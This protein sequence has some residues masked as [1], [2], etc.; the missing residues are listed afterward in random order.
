MRKF[1]IT[2]LLALL[3]C[4][5][6]SAQNTI[7]VSACNSGRGTGSFSNPYSKIFYALDSC[8]ANDTVYINPGIYNE[9]SLF[10]KVNGVQ[11]IGKSFDNF[12]TTANTSAIIRYSNNSVLKFINI[13]EKSNILLKNIIVDMDS[14][15]SECIYIDGDNNKVTNCYIKRFNKDAI[16]I[17]G[18]CYN[19]ISN[20]IIGIVEDTTYKRNSVTVE[21]SFIDGVYLTADNNLIEGNIIFHNRSHFGINMILVTNRGG[22]YDSTQYCFG[23]IIRRNRIDS[24]WS[25][26]YM[27]H[28]KNFD[29]NNNIISNSAGP[30]N[31][32][33]GH[34]INID[35]YPDRWNYYDA[36]GVIQNNDIYNNTNIGL[37][38]KYATGLQVFNNIFLDN[39]HPDAPGNGDECLRINYS[40]NDTI[41]NNLYYGRVLHWQL[42]NTY[43]SDSSSWKIIETNAIFSDPRLLDPPNKD[44]RLSSSSPAIDRGLDLTPYS[45]YHYDYVGTP[46]PQGLHWDVG[47]Y[48][49]TM[50]NPFMI[51][52]VAVSGI[53]TVELTFNRDINADLVNRYSFY[54]DNNIVKDVKFLA[55]D[56][57]EI[58]ANEFEGNKKYILII[59]E[60]VDKLGNIISPQYRAFLL[61]TEHLGKTSTNANKINSF[62][63]SQNYP[64]P[65][66]PSTSIKCNIAEDGKYQLK[67]YNVLGEEVT[68]LNN[69]VLNRGEHSFTFNAAN[70]PSGVYIYRLTGNNVNISRKMI[71]LK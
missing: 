14:S 32:I 4:F 9:D 61:K 33:E 2:L 21:G 49:Y 58:T 3:E 5:N 68:V 24:C 69:G 47:C 28:Q 64:N 62:S 51:T 71:L 34:G 8:S 55:P 50:M 38:S 41:N 40:M 66:N 25:G 43:Y 42:N 31:S 6:I 67:I 16:S 11:L 53:N 19:V 63:L 59:N 18:S 26:I 45:F 44:F 22:I 37:V 15:L 17:V 10:F 29:I 30:D 23:N 70:L 7:Y 54:I 20:N 13:N 27:R 46:R 35:S 65:F 52:N 12:C 39:A 1:T 60:L 56:K 57:L 48:E 36:R